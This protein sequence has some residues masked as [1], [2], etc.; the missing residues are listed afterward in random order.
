M[1]FTFNSL[2]FTLIYE[3]VFHVYMNMILPEIKLTVNIFEI[4]F[5]V[6]LRKIIKYL[7]VPQT[8]RN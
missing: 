5:K 1:L 7:T 6:F 2:Y 8:V 4:D 3:I